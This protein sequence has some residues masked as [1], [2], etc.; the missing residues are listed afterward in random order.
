MREAQ[1]ANT[2]IHQVL[3]ATIKQ[4]LETMKG[5]I[6]KPDGVV[7]IVNSPTPSEVQLPLFIKIGQDD[8][9]D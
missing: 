1:L 4:L 3:Y 6:P 7:S 5:G 2:H 8:V 9:G